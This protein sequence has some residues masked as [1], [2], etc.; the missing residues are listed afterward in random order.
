MS[1]FR[2]RRF[3]HYCNIFQFASLMRFLFSFSNAVTQFLEVIKP[4]LSRTCFL[5]YA[6]ELKVITASQAEI[7]NL[8]IPQSTRFGQRAQTI[9][10]KPS[11]WFC[12]SPL[13]KPCNNESADNRLNIS[14]NLLRKSGCKQFCWL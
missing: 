11:F 1:F 2:W 9:L 7:C 8:L 5:A 4:I 12:V 10:F 14:C 3:L 13:W 6:P